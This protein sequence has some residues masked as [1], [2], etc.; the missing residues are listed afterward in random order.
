VK[1]DLQDRTIR[2]EGPKGQLSWSFRPEV[3]VR[4]DDAARQVVVDRNTDERLGRALHGTTRMLIANMIEGCQNGFTR[5]LEVYGVGYGVQVQGQQVSLSV[6]FAYP[7]TFDIPG[8]VTVEVQIAQ[9]R[10][11]T[12]PARFTVSGADKQA[13]GEFAARL[14]KTK[15]SE[16]YKGKGLRY[17][18]EQIRRKAGKQFGGAGSG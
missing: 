4:Y 16:P 3:S 11:D 9:A 1:V 12:E 15:V 18:G 17:T 14:R 7:R 5:G 13:V 2:V 8:G 10:G 6:G